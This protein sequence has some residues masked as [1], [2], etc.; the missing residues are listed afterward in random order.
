MALLSL[1]NGNPRSTGKPARVE[2]QVDAATGQIVLP[3]VI[4]E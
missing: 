4:E 1:S 2:L 3:D